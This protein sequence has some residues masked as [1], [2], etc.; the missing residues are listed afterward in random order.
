MV[1]VI[2]TVKGGNVGTRPSR[3]VDEALALTDDENRRK[4]QPEGEESDDGEDDTEPLE[5]TD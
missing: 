2:R 3:K 4:S 5:G 1:M